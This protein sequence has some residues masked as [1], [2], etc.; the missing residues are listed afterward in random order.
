MF[1]GHKD[2]MTVW[3][4][5]IIALAATR[6]NNGIDAEGQALQALQPSPPSNIRSS[7]GCPRLLQVESVIS[8]QKLK[9]DIDDIKRR[10]EG[11]KERIQRETSA[12]YEKAKVNPLAGEAPC[13]FYFVF[14]HPN[15]LK[16]KLLVR[17]A[18][19]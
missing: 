16:I 14:L 2:K 17:S 15:S 3:P 11:D 9:P 6:I 13:P 12:L 1:T 19:K 8:A 7:S 4:A 10:Y 5:D 18:Q